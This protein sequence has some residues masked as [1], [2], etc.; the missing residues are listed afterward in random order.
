MTN[1]IGRLCDTGAR[2]GADVAI[3]PTGHGLTCD[4]ECPQCGQTLDACHVTDDGRIMFNVRTI[5]ITTRS[6]ALA[7]AII[8][9]T[10]GKE[11]GCENHS[12][13]SHT[14]PSPSC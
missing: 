8:G 5:M 6:V 2:H 11:R 12:T 10:L 9:R 7:C 4:Y 3:R 1:P 13:P 14:E